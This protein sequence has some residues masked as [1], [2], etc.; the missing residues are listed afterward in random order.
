[1][2][3]RTRTTSC[4]MFLVT[5]NDVLQSKPA[6]YAQLCLTPDDNMYYIGAMFDRK[7]LLLRYHDTKSTQGEIF[8]TRESWEKVPG[9]VLPPL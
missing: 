8:T 4:T 9:R 6:K 2:K 7:A 5:C 1:M 3:K